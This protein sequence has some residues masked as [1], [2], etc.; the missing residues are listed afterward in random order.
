M[1]ARSSAVACTN[2]SFEPSAGEMK[3]N[4]FAPLKNFTVPLILMLDPSHCVS[5]SQSVEPTQGNSRSGKGHEAGGA[6]CSD[7]KRERGPTIGSHRRLG[8]GRL[9]RRLQVYGP[10]KC[11]WPFPLPSGRIV[12]TDTSPTRIVTKASHRRNGTQWMTSRAAPQPFTAD[13]ISWI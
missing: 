5:K 13:C 10:E 12:V 11:P 3:P 8:Y 2:T 7:Q 4:P 1:P 9:R 6:M